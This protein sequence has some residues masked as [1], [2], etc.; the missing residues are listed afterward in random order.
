M[1]QLHAHNDKG[2]SP[3]ELAGN[4]GVTRATVTGLLDG[5]E[6]ENLVRREPNLSDRRALMIHLTSEGKKRLETILPEHFKRIQ[7]L[8]SGLDD[9]EKGNLI[10]LLKKVGANLTVL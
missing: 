5:L 10:A 2:L 8:M 3:S 7:K 9:N 6:R 4:L 1:I